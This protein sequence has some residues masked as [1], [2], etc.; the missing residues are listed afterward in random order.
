M[1]TNTQAFKYSTCLHMIMTTGIHPRNVQNE[2]KQTYKCKKV[3]QIIHLR[4]VWFGQQVLAHSA[5]QAVPVQNGII[6]Q[7]IFREP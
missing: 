1:D 7:T 5:G 3:T 4:S 2:Q 6:S